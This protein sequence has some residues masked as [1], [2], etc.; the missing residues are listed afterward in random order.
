MEENRRRIQIDLD[1]KGAVK[2]TLFGKLT[3]HFEDGSPIG[4]FTGIGEVYCGNKKVFEGSYVNG[5]KNGRGK[6]LYVDGHEIECEYKDNI[7]ISDAK[8]YK[9]DENGG[10]VE[11]NT[12][13]RLF[14]LDKLSDSIN[15][16]LYLDGNFL[17]EFAYLYGKTSTGV[18][19]YID[20]S[21]K[22]GIFDSYGA[23][24]EGTFIDANGDRYTGEFKDDLLIK[25]TT[26]YANGDM[27]DGVRSGVFGEIF[28]GIK[29]YAN[30]SM[31]IGRFT[32]ASCTGYGVIYRDG[33]LKYK[34]GLV[35]D[36]YNDKNGKQYTEQRVFEGEFKN[37]VKK[38]GVFYL[39]KDGK[40]KPLYTLT[41]SRGDKTKTVEYFLSGQK[42]IGERSDL[43]LIIDQD[44]VMHWIGNTTEKT[45]NKAKILLNSFDET[46]SDAYNYLLADLISINTN[47]NIV[48]L[49]N[50]QDLDEINYKF[51]YQLNNFLNF[52]KKPENKG[53]VVT[54][55]LY[56]KN[57]A[58]GIIYKNGKVMTVDTS[59]VVSEDSDNK[60]NREASEILKKNNVA[61][62]KQ[63]I[64]STGNCVLASRLLTS[65]L[66]KSVA[67]DKI[68]MDKLIGF[69]KNSDNYEKFREVYEKLETV[70]NKNKFLYPNEEYSKE[71]KDNID[72]I[73]E[74]NLKGALEYI[75]EL[76]AGC[77]MGI[78][79]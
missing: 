6:Y 25:G 34:G 23:L 47:N 21:I 31:Y 77:E 63:N 15:M 38:S 14:G 29:R 71:I 2:R 50:R 16:M 75:N 8:V 12:I 53:K 52:A 3:Y 4:N 18:C 41:T 10:R 39:N 28:T 76:N 66:A 37:N 55:E 19:Y 48:Q 59:G 74:E 22:R 46:E 27:D 17:G 36:K 54:S 78:G 70:C 45:K 42:N 73:T 33:L 44:N 57:H 68:T 30:G 64:Q 24:K 32:G 1:D 62:F 69:S 56:T 35:Y 11:K 26:Y 43:T 49:C 79:I 61:M 51:E 7:P 5:K 9:I 67:D 72:K 20:G 13:D 40:K 65:E 60:W 58:I